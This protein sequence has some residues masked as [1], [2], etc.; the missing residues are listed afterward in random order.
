MISIRN[1]RVNNNNKIQES[2]SKPTSK[3]GN[4]GGKGKEKDKGEKPGKDKKEERFAFLIDVRDE[5]G[6]RPSDPGYDPSTL[7]I[8]NHDCIQ[9]YFL[10]LL[11]FA[12]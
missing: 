1:S 11:L 6:R 4:L 7:F 12:F 9:F 3:F 8:P 10:C 2:P 5:N